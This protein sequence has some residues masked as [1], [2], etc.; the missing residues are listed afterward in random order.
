MGDIDKVALITGAAR[1]IG[2][3]I[4]LRLHAQGYRLLIHYHQSQQ[5]ALALQQQCNRIRAHSA[6]IICQNLLQAD[7]S[8]NIALLAQQQ[9]GRL[10][11]LVNNAS[12]FYD[13]TACQKT[14]Q[15]AQDL[16]N[17]NVIVPYVL[18]QQMRPLLEQSKGNIIN[19]SDIHGSKA[20]HHYS[21]YSQSKA[22]LILQ[23][24][25]LAKEFAPYIRVNA[26]APGAIDWPEG[27]NAL[28]EA[29]KKAILAK[30]PLAQHGAVE[31]IASALIS[32]LENCYITGQN[33][34]VDGGRSIA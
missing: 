34:A 19:I 21:L 11:L 8:K 26:I 1:R 18:S 27:N 32:I 15:L 29:Q 16:F 20:L 10:D 6:A 30:I 7:A 2:K 25:S 14:P 23:T 33:I 12:V 3:G 22:A 4:A 13:D 31:N 28:N 5:E 24:Q 17:C 9:F